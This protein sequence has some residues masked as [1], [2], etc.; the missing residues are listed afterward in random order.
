METAFPCCVKCID[1]LQSD[2]VCLM[3][4]L[5]DA[6]RSADLLAM[7]QRRGSK[8]CDRHTTGTETAVDKVDQL[9]VG[10]AFWLAVS[11]LIAGTFLFSAQSCRC[12]CCSRA[13]GDVWRR[14]LRISSSSALRRFTASANSAVASLQRLLMDCSQSVLNKAAP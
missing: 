11:V 7:R 6:H 3:R 5:V 9:V 2:S 10:I 4:N 14:K 13:D 12:C 1:H 8:L